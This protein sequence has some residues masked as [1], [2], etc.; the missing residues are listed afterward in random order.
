[1]MIIR[2]VTGGHVL[3]KRQNMPNSIKSLTLK[4]LNLLEYYQQDRNN[5]AIKLALDSFDKANE[6]DL[7]PLLGC[8]KLS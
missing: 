1:M 8:F 3:P 5:C 2:T 4:S 6:K 7:L